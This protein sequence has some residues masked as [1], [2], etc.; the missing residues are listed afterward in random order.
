MNNVLKEGKLLDQHGNLSECGYSNKLIKDYSRLDIKVSKLRIKE[1]DYYYVG[2]DN[3][4]VALTIADN[5]YMGLVS[6]SILDFKEK[7]YKNHA[8]MFWFCMGKTNLPNSSKH[9]ITYKKGK[10]YEAK[11]EVNNGKRHLYLK[12][13]NYEGKIFETDLDLTET[14]DNSLVIATPFRKKKHFY[15]NQKINNMKA[16]GNFKYGDFS[17]Y[18]NENAY[19][20]LDWGRG[21]WTYSNSW[22]WSSLSGEYNGNII[23]FNLGYGFGDTSKASENMLFIN[24][25]YYKLDDVKFNIPLDEHGK[26]KY[27]EE[28]TF[29]S[30]KN[31]INLKFKPILDRHDYTNAV[32]L[33]QDAHQVFGRFSGTFK[34]DDKIIQIKDMIGFAEKVKNKW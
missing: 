2:D 5:G 1:W 4:G 6:A 32:I 20:V 9:G 18:F 22:Y 33:M 7:K 11:F 21:V 26:E 3:Y 16:N 29:T 10:G 23:G 30:E 27:L 8:N 12:I 25:K 17:Y 34:V 13:D 31:D 14:S 15:Y 24:D 28:W 19:G